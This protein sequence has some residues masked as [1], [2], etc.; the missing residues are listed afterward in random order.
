MHH[1]LLVLI[2]SYLIIEYLLKIIM[3]NNFISCFIL[4]KLMQPV[5]ASLGHQFP[6]LLYQSDINFPMF[7][8]KK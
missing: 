3:L 5:H 1:I 6:L 8:L 2:L 4:T 7:F